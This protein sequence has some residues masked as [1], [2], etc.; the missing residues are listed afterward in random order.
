MLPG[1]GRDSELEMYV[2]FKH[3]LE[4]LDKAL[5]SVPPQKMSGFIYNGITEGSAANKQTKLFFV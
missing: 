3:W 5:V 1:G 2:L 4:N